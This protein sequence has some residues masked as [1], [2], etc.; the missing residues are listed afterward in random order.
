M[1]SKAGQS[2]AEK[3]LRARLDEALQRVSEAE[4][5]VA[6]QSASIDHAESACRASAAS[7]QRAT[8]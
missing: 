2:E 8:E 7:A 1:A 4:R 5:A 3:A 6:V